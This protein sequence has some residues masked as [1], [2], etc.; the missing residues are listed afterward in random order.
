MRIDCFG[1]PYRLLGRVG[2]MPS[3][4]SSP[5]LSSAGIDRVFGTTGVGRVVTVDAPGLIRRSGS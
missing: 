1:R 4:L 2:E 3:I 5:R